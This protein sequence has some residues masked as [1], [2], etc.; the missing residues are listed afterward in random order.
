MSDKLN[1]YN[2]LRHQYFVLNS[3]ERDISLTEEMNDERMIFY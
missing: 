3:S 2:V 1:V